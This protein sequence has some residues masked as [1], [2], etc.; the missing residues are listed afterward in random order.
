MKVRITD[1]NSKL[2]EEILC[3]SEVKSIIDGYGREVEGR[4]NANM[5]TDKSYQGSKGFVYYGGKK[6][7]YRSNRYMGHVYT[8]DIKSMIAE[9]E[10][11]ALSRA[12]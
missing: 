7:A 2:C 4:A 5:P 8:T 9:S 6:Y 11:K 1:W 10:H 12:L 3:S